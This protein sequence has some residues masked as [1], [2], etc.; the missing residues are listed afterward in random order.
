MPADALKLI[1][2][3]NIA[4]LLP[5]LW[6]ERELRYRPNHFEPE[7]WLVPAVCDKEMIAIDVGAN[8]GVYSYYMSK[9]S[10]DVIAFEPNTDL[11]KDLRRLLGK[12]FHLEAVALSGKVSE[13]TLRIDASN[14]GISTIEENND[15]ICAKDKEAI[16]SRVVQTRPLDGY[17]LSEVSM[18]KIDVEGHEE[19]V[20]EGAGD[21]IR[22]NRPVLIIESEDRHNPGSPRRL[23]ETFLNMAYRVFY[24]KDRQLLEFDSLREEDTDPERIGRE[25]STYINNFVFIPSEQAN[26]IERAQAL[27]F[28]R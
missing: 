2:G 5:R 22:R 15:M 11:W 7:L 4:R 20:I 9:F 12:E 26:K 19:A 23:A 13:A 21:T 1:V 25:G 28:A 17:Q 16:V 3:R 14:S 6:M 8:T 10:R 27:L 18:I 24:V